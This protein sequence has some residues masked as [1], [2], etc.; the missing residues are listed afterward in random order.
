MSAWDDF[1]DDFKK[2]TSAKRTTTK[3]ES[4]WWRDVQK[5]IFAILVITMALGSQCNIGPFRKHESPFK[6]KPRQQQQQ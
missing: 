3:T 5:L 2:Y 4:V 1:R 6:P